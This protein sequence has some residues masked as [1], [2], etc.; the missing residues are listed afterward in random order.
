VRT[1]LFTIALF[2]TQTA[3]SQTQTDTLEV[4]VKDTLIVDLPVMD[5]GTN[6]PIDHEAININGQTIYIKQ[7]DRIIIQYIPKKEEE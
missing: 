6:I 2:L 7:T 5:E 4:K 1:I 3:F